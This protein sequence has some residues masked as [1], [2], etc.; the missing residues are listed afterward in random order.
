MYDDIFLIITM[1]CI[2]AQ[3]GAFISWDDFHMYMHVSTIPT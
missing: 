3:K 2:G 1:G